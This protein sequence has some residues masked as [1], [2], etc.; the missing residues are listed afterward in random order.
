MRLSLSLIAAIALRV[1]IRLEHPLDLAETDQSAGLGSLD[2]CGTESD[3]QQ[4]A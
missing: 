3:N 1:T 2:D 4:L